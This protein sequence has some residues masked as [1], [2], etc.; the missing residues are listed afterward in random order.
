MLAMSF[1]NTSSSN[2]SNT[3]DKIS[4]A[5]NDFTNSLYMPL[6]AYTDKNII[7]SPLSLHVLLSLLSNGAG[8]STLDELRSTLGY[9]DKEFLNDEFKALII[10][11]NDM[12]N[13]TLHVANAAY[14]QKEVDLTGDFLST[15]MNIFQSL[16]SKIDFEDKIHAAETI[17]TW[18]QVATHNKI[19]NIISPDDI[20]VDTKF[21]LL[22]AVHFKSRWL[23]SFN[24]ENTQQRKFYVSRTETYFVPTMFTKATYFYGEIPLW[25]TQF[26]EIPYLNEDIV[27]VILLPDR[28]MELQFLEKKFNWQ[29]LVNRH[30]FFDDFE[31]YLPKFKFEITINLK[32]ILKKIGLNMMFKDDC[33]FRHISKFPLKVSNVL[34]KIF[35][36]VNEQGTEA[37]IVTAVKMKTKRMAISPM[38]FIVDRPF[39][40]AIEH[41][42]TKL[43]LFL[44]SVRKLDSLVKDEL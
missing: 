38:E 18:V 10:L 15:C 6:S 20:S 5:C 34:Q 33:D 41:K 16:I 17:N 27:M 35:I 11:L 1:E 7:I 39:M 29:T 3:F 25:N 36:E 26:I 32:D 30:R 21:V 13:V 40:F 4:T 44:G 31:L 37:A 22:N 42:P 12:R 28:E 8:G 19:S 43:P 2:E 24:E 23:K 9:S 14:I